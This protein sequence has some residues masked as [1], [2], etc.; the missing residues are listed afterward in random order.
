MK[1]IAI[2]T[3]GQTLRSRSMIAGLAVSLLYLAAVPL[4]STTG[5][6]PVMV[7]GS[8]EG[9]GAAPQ[10][11]MFSLSGL[12]LI[13]MFMALFIALG[14]I[15]SEIDNGTMALIITKPLSRSRVITGRW[16]GY[17]LLLTGYVLVIGLVLWLAVLLGTGTL[18]LGF[19]PALALVGLNVI[20]MM[21]LTFAI[22]VFLP[23]AANAVLVFLVFIATTNLSLINIAGGGAGGPAVAV[24]GNAF[25]LALPVGVVGDQMHRFLASAPDQPALS[26]LF[27]A[28]EVFYIVALLLLAATAFKSKDLK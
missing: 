2:Y 20:T 19:M 13:G 14:S 26:S 9:G 17:A 27:I 23:A 21:T 3:I 11:L 24:I 4:L 5:G 7:G 6:G 16:A 10:F 15:Q 22:S 25:R 1:T 12:N 8:G 28:Y 18:F